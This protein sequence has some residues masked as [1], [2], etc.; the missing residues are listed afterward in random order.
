MGRYYKLVPTEGIGVSAKRKPMTLRAARALLEQAPQGGA[1]EEYRRGLLSALLSIPEGAAHG[2]GMAMGIPAAYDQTTAMMNAVPQIPGA[3]VQ[4]ARTNPARFMGE[5]VT[6]TVAPLAGYGLVRGGR[7]GARALDRAAMAAAED[8]AHT[9]TRPAVRWGAPEYI[10]PE[11]LRI[12]ESEPLRNMMPSP[13]WRYFP[14]V[15]KRRGPKEILVR[16]KPSDPTNLGYYY[17]Y[18]T[19]DP[20]IVVFPNKSDLNTVV[21][22][23]IHAQRDALGRPTMGGARHWPSTLDWKMAVEPQ[24][25]RGGTRLAER[26]EPPRRETGWTGGMKQVEEALEKWGWKPPPGGYIKPVK[27]TPLAERAGAFKRAW[28]NKRMAEDQLSA[29]DELRKKGMGVQAERHERVAEM[30]LGQFETDWKDYQAL[31][32]GAWNQPVKLPGRG[33]R[34]RGL[35]P[36]TARS[37]RPPGRLP[38]YHNE[39]AFKVAKKLARDL[40]ARL[41]EED[42]LAGNSPDP[43]YYAWRVDLAERELDAVVRQWV[44]GRKGW[45]SG[46]VE[47]VKN[48]LIEL[49]A[50][51]LP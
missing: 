10:M 33:A 25:L 44:E 39:P 9:Y 13:L 7:A 41:K 37:L 42:R 27:R 47:W 15:T 2:L 51:E 4:Q 43:E 30:L 34:G 8:L 16:A 38:G 11:M 20:H 24:A 46:D 26:W 22:E 32:G 3:L 29:A 17:G 14:D 19:G 36:T 28:N 50:G 21:H 5:V 23:G 12:G 6:P 35:R 31:V 18:E 48:Y 40:W 49:T 45:T 1:M